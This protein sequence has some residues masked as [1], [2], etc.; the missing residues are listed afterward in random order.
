MKKIVLCDDHSIIRR[1]L[2]YLLTSHFY[3]YTVYEFNSIKETLGYLKKNTCNFA[4]FDLQVSDGNMIE[5]LPNITNLYPKMDILIYSMSNESI[6]GK[7]VLQMG[8]KGFLSKDADEEEV[9]RALQM[10]LS[11]QNYISRS[12]NNLLISDLKSN[13]NKMKENPFA[14]LSNREVEVTHHLLF[15]KGIKEIS[16]KMNL[17]ANTIVTYKNRVFEKLS[18]TNIIDLTNLAK[19]YDFV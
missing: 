10:F 1:G 15:G 2:K 19:L 14:G 6:Y 9:M 3:D 17:H 18:I 11:G 4:I 12:L 8:A 16:S 5:A 7:R 13:K